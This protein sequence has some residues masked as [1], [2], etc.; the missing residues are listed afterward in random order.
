MIMLFHQVLL[1]LQLVDF[2]SDFAKSTG[3]FVGNIFYEHGLLVFTNTGSRFVNIGTGTGND[4]YSL[5]Y[6]SQVTIREHSYTF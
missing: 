4:G 3:S 5:K 6:K 1:N 2:D